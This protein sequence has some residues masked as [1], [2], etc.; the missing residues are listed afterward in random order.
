MDSPSAALA[1]VQVGPGQVPFTRI[2]L[3][4]LESS[5]T[6][7]AAGTQTIFGLSKTFRLPEGTYLVSMDFIRIDTWFVLDVV[8]GLYGDMD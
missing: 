1:A 8:L 5:V 6:G 3:G 2:I 4:G 7:Q